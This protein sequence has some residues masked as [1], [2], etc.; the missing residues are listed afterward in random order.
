MAA[1]IGSL[2]G[3]TPAARRRALWGLALI[4]PNT[5]GL[6]IFFGVPIL[7]SFGLSL[8]DWNIFTA[9]R[10]IG[11]ENFVNLTRDPIFFKALGNTL[12]LF[13]LVVPIKIFLSILLAVLLNLKMFGVGVIRVAYILPIVTSTTAAAII[14]SW[15]FQPQVGL[16]DPILTQFGYPQMRW[17]T[18]PD[19]VLYPIAIVIIWQSLGFDMILMLSGLQSIPKTLYEAARVDGASALVRFIRITLPLLS[20]TVF[21]VVVLSTIQ[22][23]QVFDQVFVMTSS[24]VL[25]GVNNSAST[26]VFYLYQKGFTESRFG[27][28][29]AI[30]VALF[31]IIILVTGFQFWL[32]RRWVHYQA[33]DRG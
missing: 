28:A 23:I 26:A 22:L 5:L 1:N 30:A 33:E 14:W 13:L 4:L 2:L 15:I 32:Q 25:G 9:P 24:T 7:A 8:H 20:P 27:Y 31:F 12:T 19:L 21:L 10:F 18:S 29:S 3:S 11:L 17:L 16:I 6:F